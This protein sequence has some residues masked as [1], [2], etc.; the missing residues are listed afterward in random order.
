MSLSATGKKILK[1]F[2][3]EYGKKEGEQHFYAWENKH[4]KLVREIKKKGAMV[5]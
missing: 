4:K 5:D 3:R 1:E 2:E